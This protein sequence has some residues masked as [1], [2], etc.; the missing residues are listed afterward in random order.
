[1]EAP[2]YTQPN[3]GVSGA[4]SSALR[5]GGGGSFYQ[6]SPLAQ[7]GLADEG[8]HFNAFRD[9]DLGLNLSEFPNADNLLNVNAPRDLTSASSGLSGASFSSRSSAA[10]P[11]S[12]DE[13]QWY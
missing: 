10:A 3:S 8:S 9:I 1:M 5:P 6:R 12:L 11:Q 2:R 7:S 4:G 13:E